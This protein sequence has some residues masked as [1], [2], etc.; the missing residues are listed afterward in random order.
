[1][2]TPAVSLC[3]QGRDHSPTPLRHT[4]RVA[5]HGQA[6]AHHRPALN[7]DVSPAAFLREKGQVHKAGGDRTGAEGT[8]WASSPSANALLRPV[9]ST[10]CMQQWE[11]G[12]WW[13]R[14]SHYLCSNTSRGPGHIAG[15][16]ET[17]QHPT[18]QEPAPA[19]HGPH[20]GQSRS[21]SPSLGAAS[22]HCP[23]TKTKA[24][25]TTKRPQRTRE[26]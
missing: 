6:E 13:Q 22:R 25:R 11:Q 24:T 14:R 23:S 17:S 20:G 15:L 16:T 8:G 1:M 7:P 9:I 12:Q 3:S 10:T 26:Q 4:R 21:P 5:A 2:K 18:R 19:T